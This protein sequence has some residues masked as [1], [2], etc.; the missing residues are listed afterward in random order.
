MVAEIVGGLPRLRETAR[1]KS[2]SPLALDLCEKMLAKESKDRISAT[3][4]LQHQWFDSIRIP[5]TPTAEK[6][7]P[8]VRRFMSPNAEHSQ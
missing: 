7:A 3:D 1:E 6:N 8:L 4:A 5:E 2:V